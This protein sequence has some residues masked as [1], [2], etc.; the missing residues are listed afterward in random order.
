MAAA[1]SITG[2]AL[3]ARLE[4]STFLGGTGD[5][6]TTRVAVDRAGNVYMTGTTSSSQF[7]GTP[8]VDRSLGDE[9]DAFVV[10]FSP[11][12]TL[13]YAT[14]V[15]GACNIESS[16]G[17]SSRLLWGARSFF[18]SFTQGGASF[19]RLALGS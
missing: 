10:K 9:T 5:E 19:R 7:P 6:S 11:Q 14:L 2:P 13:L 17:V 12:G 18:L 4:Y 1:E 15:G 16:L 8:V 3:D